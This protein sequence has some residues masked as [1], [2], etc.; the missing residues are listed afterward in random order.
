MAVIA[1][2]WRTCGGVVE[3]ESRSPMDVGFDGAISH[4]EPI[5]PIT[6]LHASISLYSRQELT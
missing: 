2:A 1:E 4:I 3:C 5:E 6:L